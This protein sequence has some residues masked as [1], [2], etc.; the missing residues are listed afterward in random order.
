[1]NGNSRKWLYMCI[2]W[3]SKKWACHGREQTHVQ[4]TIVVVNS[5]GPLSNGFVQS[6]WC[7]PAAP[8]G[9]GSI[10]DMTFNKC[11][12]AKNGVMESSQ[13][14]C[15][16]PTLTHTKPLHTPTPPPHP[17]THTR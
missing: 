16:L 1:L 15:T 2:P 11:H 6:K 3:C 14:Y 9:S 12:S 17:P 4:H 5:N 8:H 7:V 13:T 10:S